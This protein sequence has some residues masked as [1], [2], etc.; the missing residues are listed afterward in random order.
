MFAV[1]V[2]FEITPEYIQEFSSLVEAQSANSLSQETA[3]RQFD[4]CNDPDQPERFFLYEIYDDPDAFSRHL[5]SAHFRKFD[6]EIKDMVVSKAVQTYRQ[7][8]R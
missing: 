2:Q 3:C 1:C 5:A 4:I 8:R 6:S 7:V